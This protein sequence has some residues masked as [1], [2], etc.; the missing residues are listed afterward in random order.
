MKKQTLAVV[1]FC[2]VSLALSF[3]A[4]AQSGSHGIHYPKQQQQQ[5]QQQAPCPTR[6]IREDLNQAMK[7]LDSC[8][9]SYDPNLF[10]KLPRLVASSDAWIA[11]FIYRY[12]LERASE[13]LQ[14]VYANDFIAN[15]NANENCI[16]LEKED[17]ERI[18]YDLK[19]ATVS[20]GWNK[21]F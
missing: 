8:G 12:R 15:S 21:I 4:I 2:T 5:Q 14:T 11:P 9:L 18:Q 19:F 20:C 1:V 6:A 3:A 7:N 16:A 17:L 10:A 13:K